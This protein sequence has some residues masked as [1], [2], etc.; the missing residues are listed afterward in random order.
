V[1][2]ASPLVDGVPMVTYAWGPERNPVTVAQY[3]LASYSL[4][5]RYRDPGRWHHAVRV[6]DWL[7]QT[8][9]ADGKWLYAFEFQPPGSDPLAPG[10]LDL[11]DSHQGRSYYNAVSKTFAPPSYDPI[12]RSMMLRQLTR[13]SGRPIFA[14]YAAIWNG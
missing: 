1:P 11:F 5:V 12:I 4:W 8:Q 6:A 3:G 13:M 9:T 10:T 2:R 14:R 7:V